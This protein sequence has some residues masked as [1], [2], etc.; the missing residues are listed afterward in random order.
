MGRIYKLLRSSAGRNLFSLYLIQFFAYFLPLI[1][2]PYLVR[3]L[4]PEGYGLVA[5]ATSFAGIF[6]VILDY[7]FGLTA[8]RDI[9]AFKGDTKK[10]FSIV[11]EVITTKL[12][13]SVVAALAFAGATLFTPKINQHADIF[14]WAFL[15]ILGNSF[16]PIWLYQGIGKLVK[17]NSVNLLIK[18]ANLPL[19]FLFVHS[20]SDAHK[21]VALSSVTTAVGTAY[22]WVMTIRTFKEPLRLAGRS[23]VQNQIKEG[24]PVFISQASIS[25]FTTAN[26]FILGSLTNLTIAGYFAVAEKLVRVFF[27]L[28]SPFFQILFPWAS[29]LAAKS[30]AEA[31]PKIQKGFLLVSSLGLGVSATLFLGA[32]VFVQFIF[33][34]EFEPAIE[35][36]KVMSLLP[37]LFGMGAG[38]SLLIIVPFRMERFLPWVNIAAGTINF[39][40]AFALVPIFGGGIGMAWSIV[41]AEIVVVCSEYFIASKFGLYP[42]KPRFSR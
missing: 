17:L 13:M 8:T 15:G 30:R 19:L 23:A 11:S 10:I 27:G 31:I 35:I 5:F 22:V 32:P 38:L 28:F 1:T 6:N 20:Q 39:A 40:F 26:T 37:V 7:G 9:A 12:V 33:G 25:L 4:T 2:M 3:T 41:A 14:W 21:W 18:L 16:Q 36:V 29:S 24:F 42:I 34:R